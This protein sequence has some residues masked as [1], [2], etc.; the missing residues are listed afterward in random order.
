MKKF[1][2]AAVAVLLVLTVSLCL[3]FAAAC[4]GY[5]LEAGTYTGTYKCHYTTTYE[6]AGNSGSVN[7][8]SANHW[9]SVVTF[10]VDD[11]GAIWNLAVT[12]PAADAA[13]NNEEYMTYQRAGMGDVFCAQFGGWTLAE[14]MAITVETNESGFPTRIDGN[15]KQLTIPGGQIGTCGT[16][17][18][19]MKNAIETGTKAPAAE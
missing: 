14:I 13:S 10:D 7:T 15:G 2:N 1:R 6:M 5:S 19:A 18:L 4:G 16:A 9:G 12:A 3:V 17:L 8:G 11:N